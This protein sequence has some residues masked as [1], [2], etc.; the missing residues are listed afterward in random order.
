MVDETNVASIR[1]MADLLRRGATMLAR[2]CPQ[3]GSPLMKV[4]DD[5]YCAT[6]DRRIVVVDSDEP[7]PSQ[8]AG[9]LLP[10]LKETVLRKL[11]AINELVERENDVETLTRLTN[12]LVL[13]LQALNQLDRA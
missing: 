12:L 4:G 1:K 11:R 10:E 6:C 8:S 13:L 9:A 5:I 7:E 2:P 3:C